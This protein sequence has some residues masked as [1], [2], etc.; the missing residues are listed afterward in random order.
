MTAYDEAIAIYRGLV[1]H[2]RAELANDLAMALVNK[3]NALDGLGR[4]PEAVTAYDEAIAIYRGLVEGGR[5]ELAND[6][7]NALM[8]KALVLEKQEQWS[9]ALACYEDA[10]RWR[11]ACIRAGM[12]HLLGELLGTIRYRM[13]T[14]LDLRRWEEAASDVVR[15]LEHAAPLLQSGSPP[16]GVVEETQ[17]VIELLS[18]LPDE[19]WREIAAGLGPWAG[20]VAQL[21]GR[22]NDGA[23]G[24]R[25]DPRRRKPPRGRGRGGRG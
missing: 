17:Q 13:I 10:I 1:E 9:G 16:P 4:L 23:K 12:S 15:C 11:E 22:G 3:G 5:A 8:N 18:G 21:I 19:A 2:G 20:E 25:T 24:S 6:L 14:L 7:A